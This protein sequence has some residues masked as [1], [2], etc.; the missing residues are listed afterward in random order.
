MNRVQ[1]ISHKGRRI[2][3]VDTRSISRDEQLAAAED[4]SKLLGPEPDGSALVL[5]LAGTF[6][7]H[8]DMVAKVK[9]HLLQNQPKV[10]R[11]ALVGVGGILKIAF[12]S[13]FAMARFL[14]M[15]MNEDRGKHFDNEE[16]A[17]DWLVS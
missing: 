16:E 17:K 1:W 6:D 2:L 5:V 12:E 8:A 13:F 11:S 10:R 15:T 14:G 4:Y 3:L 9:A 7:F